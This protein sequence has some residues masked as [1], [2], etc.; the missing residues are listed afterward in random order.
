VVGQIIGAG[1]ALVI[2]MGTFVPV[3]TAEDAV[4]RFQMLALPDSGVGSSRVM[5]L[6]TREGRLWQWWEAPYI[7]GV[8]NSGRAGITY[9]GKMTPGAS[10][11][12]NAYRR[13]DAKPTAPPPTNESISK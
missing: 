12:T 2:A 5:I 11:E 9:L 8:T 3:A 6:D 13:F 4:G 1:M 10:G 7:A